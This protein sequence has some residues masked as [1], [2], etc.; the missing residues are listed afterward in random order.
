MKRIAIP[1]TEEGTVDAHFG[2][3]KYFTLVD[4]NGE[5]IISEE[6][7]QAPPHEPGLLPRWLAKKGAT[8]VLAGGMGNRAIQQFNEQNVNV[9]VGSP[10]DLTVR[11][12]VTGFINKS[13]KFTANCC[14]H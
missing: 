5:N 4:V 13:V 10:G 1:I 6:I 3:C 7:I 9:F 11:E 14:D 8:D 2:H 12:L